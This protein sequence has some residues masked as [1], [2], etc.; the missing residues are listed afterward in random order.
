METRIGRGAKDRGCGKNKRE[1]QEE[2][3]KP[4]GSK[5]EKVGKGLS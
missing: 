1:G 5:G 3:R 4:E 2:E